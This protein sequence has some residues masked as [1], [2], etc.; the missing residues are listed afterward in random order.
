MPPMSSAMAHIPTA[1][2]WTIRSVVACAAQITS[3]VG[4]RHDKEDPHSLLGPD[5]TKVHMDVLRRKHV[6]LL[7]SDLDISHDEIQ[8]LEV[9]YNYERIREQKVIYLYGGE[10]IEWIQSFTSATK[11]VAQLLPLA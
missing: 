11:T 3:L 1:A 6:L 8:V 7:I 4:L 2:Y 9:Q 5:K 10:E